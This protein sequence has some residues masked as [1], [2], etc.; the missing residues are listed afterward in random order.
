MSPIIG[1]RGAAR[2]A[3]ENTLAGI[4]AAAA[5]G[6]TWVEMDVILMGDGALIMHH[7][8]TL[9]RCTTGK[10]EVL[11]L[12]LADLQNI[13]AA[14]LFEKEY[15]DTFK[16]EPVPTLQEALDLT[17]ELGMG[18]NLEI[19]MHNHPVTDLVLPVLDVLKNHPLL[20]EGKLI[21]SSFDHEALALCHQHSPEIPLGHLFEGLPSNW[22]TLTT[23]VNAAT[24]HANQRKLTQKK[25]QEVC[26]AG[27]ELYCYTV[28]DAQKARQLFEWGASGIFTDDP[29]EVK[30][31]IDDN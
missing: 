27:Y 8:K 25:V 21:I 22:L 24:V 16:G 13:D 23:E 7:D 14:K 12:G 15:G 28:N 4:R 10:G 31:A 30:T 29:E 5:C 6:V 1:H 26:E 2:I 17:H 11:A 20:R 9:N 19:K 18:M 3:P